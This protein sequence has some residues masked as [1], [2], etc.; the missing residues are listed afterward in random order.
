MPH[1]IMVAAMAFTMSGTHSTGRMLLAAAVLV[2]TSVVCAPLARADPAFRDHII[3]LWAMV[4]I[5]ISLMPSY[6]HAPLA[7]HEHMMLP[8][9]PVG[10]VA[11]VFGWALGR[12]LL[13]RRRW[14][15]ATPSGVIFLLATVLMIGLC[16]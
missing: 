14:R 11:I 5:L 4:M 3:D 1:A 16:M 10:M 7:Y 9:G 13:G 15:S 2:V 12:I 6:P 8:Q